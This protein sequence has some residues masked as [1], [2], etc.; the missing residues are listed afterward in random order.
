MAR[1]N[2]NT[3]EGIAAASNKKPAAA[4]AVDTRAALAKLQSGQSL[5]DDEKRALGLP[6][7]EAPADD[8]GATGP[9]GPTGPVA[10]KLPA[11]F[12]A[13]AF[14]KELEAFFGPASGYLGYKIDTRTDKNGKTYSQLSVATGPNSSQTFG[15]GFTQGPDGK[16]SSYSPESPSDGGVNNVDTP[17]Q[18][19]TY[20]APDGRM[21]TSLEAYNAY[22]T[23]TKAEEKRRAGQSAYDI[24]YAE[25]DKYGLGSLVKEVQQYIVD[26]LSPA[27]FTL[28]LRASKPYQERFAGNAKRIANGFRAIDEATYLGLEDAY[29]VIMQNYG[30]PENYYARG[31]LGVQKGFED[32]IGGNVDPITLE[33][34]I[35]EGQK[36]TKGNKSIIDTAKQFFPTLTDGDFLA[37]VLNPKSGLEEIKRKVTAVEIGAGAAE[38]GLGINLERALE[39]GTAGIN[40][41]QAKQGYAAIAG[42]VQRGSQLA[43]MLGENPYTQ[44]VAEEEVFGLAGKTKAA[45]QRQKIIGLEKSEFGAKTGISSGALVRD[46][47]GAY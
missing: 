3:P 11:G 21:F 4:P 25:F 14:P 32:L 44:T 8:S 19:K 27:E 43:A 22:L 33:E 16:Y 20:T 24:L 34:R 45:E 2:T 5:T 15:A 10:G 36:V 13:G 42:G 40:K 38:A 37:Y 26:G 31:N 6:V 35:I 23:Q 18:G 28:K 7:A 29:Q 12:T 46:R 41:A 30:L 47:A 17:D 39:L 9:T 1:V